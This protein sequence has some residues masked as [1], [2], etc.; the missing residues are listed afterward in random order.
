[1][2][3]LPGP[4]FIVIPAGLAILSLEFAF[5]RR[6]LHTIRE[7]SRERRGSHARRCAAA[8]GLPR[9]TPVASGA[10]LAA[11]HRRRIRAA[12]ARS[13]AVVPAH[14][15]VQL[16]LLPVPA[17]HQ[18]HVIVED[19][20]PGGG[21]VQLE[22]RRA[23]RARSSRGSRAPRGAR[24]RPRPRA[25]R[26]T[27]RRDSRSAISSP[28][29]CA[30]RRPGTGRGSVKRRRVLVDL[31]ARRAARDDLAE[32]AVGR[33]AHGVSLPHVRPRSECGR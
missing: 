10:A 20:L 4:A 25:P 18:V 6:W 7:R 23:R 21:A 13:A 12:V 5:A 24:S 32:D 1:M 16:E 2:I 14:A 33:A 29:A 15:R 26:A 27:P 11:L 19:G 31:G 28:P 8:R 9:C 3:V 17:R 30:P 22:R